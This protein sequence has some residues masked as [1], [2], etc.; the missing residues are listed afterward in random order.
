LTGLS[1][2]FVINNNLRIT[3]DRFN[4]ELLRDQR[5]GLS[6]SDARV[7]GYTAAAGGGGRGGFGGGAMGAIDYNLGGLASGFL[8]SYE[9]Y[10]RRDLSFTGNANAIFY[11]LSGG[12]SSY[13]ST[14]NDDASLAGAFARNPNL[15]LYVAANYFDLNECFSGRAR[16]QHHGRPLRGRA[17]DLYR[18]QGAAQV[19]ERTGQVHQRSGFTDS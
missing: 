6:N 13:T 4:A 14:G 11:L 9:A 2:A 19:A 12:V 3:L 18:Q 16:S 10:L 17:D 8:T 5:R 1:K 7:T 15:R